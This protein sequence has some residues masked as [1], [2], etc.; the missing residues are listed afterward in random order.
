MTSFADEPFGLFLQRTCT[1]EGAIANSAGTI[2]YG[3]MDTNNCGD[4]F[5][6]LELM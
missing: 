2:T 5:A 1:A 3:G 6:T 4:V